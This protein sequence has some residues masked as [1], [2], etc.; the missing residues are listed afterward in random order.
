MR[1]RSPEG[2]L[3]PGLHQKQRDQQGKG[4]DSAPLLGSD[5][6][7]P[8]VLYPALEPSEQEKHGPVGAGPEEGHK[9]DLRA[10]TPLPWGKAVQPG[11]EKALGTPYRSLLVPEG[12]LQESWRADILQGH[13]MTGQ[14]VMR[15]N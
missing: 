13:G 4:G 12:G 14:G 1:A 15:L 6:T 7:P 10:G 3:Y 2:Q 11:E 9:N 5:E 8:G